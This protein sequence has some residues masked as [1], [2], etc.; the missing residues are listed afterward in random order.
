[1]KNDCWWDSTTI[2]QTKVWYSIFAKRKNLCDM[3]WNIWKKCSFIFIRFLGFFF[4][5]SFWI[6]LKNNQNFLKIFFINF[7]FLPAMLLILWDFALIS[8][9]SFAFHGILSGRR[10]LFEPVDDCWLNL[11]SITGRGLAVDN[12][13]STWIVAD[14]LWF[15][16]KR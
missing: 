8:S 12:V 10:R 16:A 11:W 14:G 5:N 2:R 7:D 4:N 13:S 6:Q 3:L 1:M 9:F 15:K